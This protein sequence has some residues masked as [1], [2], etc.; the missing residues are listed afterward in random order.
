MKMDAVKSWPRPLTPSDIRS[1]LG[2]AEACEKSF[3]K[4]KDRLTSA[5]VLTLS[6][7]TDDFV[8]YCDASRIGLGCVLMKNGKVIAYSSRQLKFWKSFQKGIGT[9]VKLSTTFHPQIDGQ[10][11]RTI[12]T[13]EDMLR[14]CV[15][16]FKG[17]WD[18]HL[19]LIE[20]AYNNSNHSSID[21][22]LFEALYSRRCRSPIE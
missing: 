8:V 14:A 7:G 3:Q 19:P 6:E 5:L 15:N 21:M 18:D 10:V 2:L 11:E 17:N 20:F 4:L 22:A 1:F 16:D 9:K 12:Q 13:L